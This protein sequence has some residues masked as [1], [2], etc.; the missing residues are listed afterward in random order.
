MAQTQDEAK[1]RSNGSNTASV[2]GVKVRSPKPN[3]RSSALFN[4]EKYGRQASDQT[5]SLI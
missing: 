3:R 2:D 5:K 1:Q 4:N